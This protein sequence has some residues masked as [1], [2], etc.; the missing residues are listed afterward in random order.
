MNI[1]IYLKHNKT[2]EERSLEVNWLMKNNNGYHY[3]LI[4]FLIISLLFVLLP[5]AEGQSTGES[6]DYTIKI[7]V[8]YDTDCG[9]G[10]EAEPIIR[11]FEENNTHLNFYWYDAMIEENLTLANKFFNAYNVPEY[12]RANFPFLFV[13]D[14]FFGNLQITNITLQAALDKYEGRNVPLWPEW[15]VA[16]TIN[17]AFF[18]DSQSNSGLDPTFVIENLNSTHYQTYL[19]DIYDDSYNN[20]LLEEYYKVYATSNKAEHT[21]L[22]IGDHYLLDDQ[23]TYENIKPILVSYEG[24]KVQLKNVTIPLGGGNIC[25][26]FFYS[27]TC[28]E[29]YIANL[30]LEE[31]KIKYPDLDIN[32][33]STSDR[34][35]E[36]LKQ[37]YYEYYDVPNSKRGTMAVFIG[38]KYFTTSED[39]RNDF[40]NEVKK[41]PDGV[42][43]QDVEP[44]EDIVIDLFNSF[45][46][47]VIMAAGLIDGLNP[48]AF[49][50]LIFFI[51]YLT[52]TGN[53]RKR[54]LFIGVSFTFGIF[55]TYFILGIGLIGL[56]QSFENFSVVALIIYPITAIIAFV[57]GFYNTYDYLKAKEGKKDEMKLKL[58]DKIK[59]SISS[60]IKD[61]SKFK[62]FI[63][64]A[65]LTGVII[66]L[67]EFMC[68]GQV[69]LP[70]IIFIMGVPEYQSQAIFYLLLYNIMFILPL[71]IIFVAVYFGMSSG[72]LQAVLET[73]RSQLKLFTAII[74]Y[75]LGIFIIVF[76]IRILGYI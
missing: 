64:V 23:I 38:D 30:F 21:A 46:V 11:S 37:S 22:F 32:K 76:F 56:I 65:F 7:A 10:Y 55:L 53:E 72:K 14:Y 67:L 51:T 45:G 43:C 36:V 1:N 15:D 71:I 17:M 68:T 40:E 34:D 28:S 5:P 75:L 16:W 6:E 57:F 25:V 70:T 26:T 74:L 39:L 63:F 8:F 58:P 41:Y 2:K 13:G 61:Q 54:I 49:A 47:N 3:F 9:C 59:K 50:T 27:P 52:I 35:N 42:T 73:R 48:C 18:Y 24:Q 44:D 4:S 31:M 66:S 62:Y 33:Y 20:T 69:Y 12:F 19:Y 60:V 29:C